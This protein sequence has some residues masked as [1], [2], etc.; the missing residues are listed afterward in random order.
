[1]TKSIS[2]K[3]P[4]ELVL[5]IGRRAK[6]LRVSPDA[7]IRRAIERMNQ[8]TQALLRAQRLADASKKARKESMRVNREFLS[9]DSRLEDAIDLKAIKRRSDEPTRPFKQVLKNLK[10][11][12]LLVKD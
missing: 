9:S 1:M 11:D 8:Q 12:R 7:Y 2:I 6:T 10:R 5:E 3:L 4:E